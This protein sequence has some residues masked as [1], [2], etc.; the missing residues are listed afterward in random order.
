[1]A[2][3][4]NIPAGMRFLGASEPGRPRLPAGG[5][6]LRRALTPLTAWG[7]TGPC[8]EAL[9]PPA[10]HRQRRPRLAIAIVPSA[11]A[12]VVVF[13]ACSGD[14]TTTVTVRETVTETATSSVP[15]EAPGVV[16]L[17]FLRDGKV[18][19]VPRGVVSGPDVAAT[20]IDELVTGPETDDGDVES[21]IPGGAD[22]AVEVNGDLAI[23]QLTPEPKERAA[24]AQVVY[25]LTAIRSIKRVSFGGATPVGRRAF[26]AQTPAIFVESPL[27]DEQVESGF[28]VTGTANTFEATFNYELK[29]AQGK[30]LRKNF[31]TAT[32]GS[33]T[34][35]TF[36][37]TVPYTIDHPQQGQLV[38]FELSAED[39]SRINELEIPLRLE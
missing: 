18:T 19:P 28:E 14:G 2:L 23:V 11:L 25:T 33:G 35:G 15:S 32:S 39:G 36:K 20:A 26:E 37:F 13:A 22:G 34:R 38:V 30:I 1:L 8:Q 10:P 12:A 5:A 31:V 27:P 3:T 6:G 17:F 29:D 21:A 4:P 16:T 24:R 7:S 9:C